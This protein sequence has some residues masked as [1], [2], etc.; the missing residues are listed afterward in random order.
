MKIVSWNINGWDEDVRVDLIT[1]IEQV[2][3][4]FILLQLTKTAGQEVDLSLPGYHMYTNHGNKEKYGG[5]ISYCVIPASRVTY[6]LHDSSFNEE[7]RVIT[8][9]YQSFY[10]VNVYTPNIKP[11]KSR[12]Q[13]RVE[14]DQNAHR[15]YKQ[16]RDNKM[17]LICGDFN[18]VIDEKDMFHTTFHHCK[19]S[20]TYLEQGMFKELL[21]SG[22]IDVYRA[23]HPT[24][25]EYSFFSIK[26]NHRENNEG[27]RSD[28]V[29]VSK[30]EIG[31][32]LTCQILQDY[33]HSN[34]KPLYVEVMV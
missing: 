5:T 27:Y 8:L 16:L 4:D 7:G 15:Y 11:N 33:S 6:G 17:V 22:F 1:I 31:Y 32:C 13:Y 21:Q 25:I 19:P 18:V 30:E 10:L 2:H 28:Y 9:E 26:G 20:Q 24:T 12:A 29:L 3:P 14:F 34:H 23:L